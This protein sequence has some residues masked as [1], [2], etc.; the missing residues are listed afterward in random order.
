MKFAKN[1]NSNRPVLSE[2]SDINKSPPHKKHE[3]LESHKSSLEKILRFIK[4]SISK[5][6]SNKNNKNNKSLE[7][8]KEM[9]IE[10][11]QIFRYKL[12]EKKINMDFFENLISEKKSAITNKIFLDKN[13]SG[14]YKNSKN[15]KIYNLKTEIDLLK[16][17]NF[18]A[19]NDIQFINNSM[20]KKTNEYNYLK[21]Y[22]PNSTL[23]EKETI[24]TQQ[25]YYPIVTKIIHKKLEEVHE[26]F[27]RITSA[28]KKQNKLIE[29]INNNLV[30]LKN[31]IQRRK[32]NFY[33]NIKE[34]IKE[35][36]KEYT[37]TMLNITVNNINNVNNIISAYNKINKYN[38][39]KKEKDEDIKENDFD[40]KEENDDDDI[41]NQDDSNSSSNSSKENNYNNKIQQTKKIPGLN[42]D[43]DKCHYNDDIKYNT[44]RDQ[45]VNSYFIN[46]KSQRFKNAIPHILTSRKEV[47]KAD[48]INNI[49][50]DKKFN[51]IN[52]SGDNI[53]N[54]SDIST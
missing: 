10:L 54:S 41:F 39:K 1:I 18:K 30:D 23:Q 6:V 2:T 33:P 15:Q 14:K 32:Y 42:L 36:S 48:F 24:C 53:S 47:N 45:N 5:I 26:K 12:E 51:N 49:F 28:K 37:K 31:S 4:E 38:L 11:N 35:E 21:L 27:K 19:T 25:K 50:L 34:I 9:L 46:Q 44:S 3:I 7:E 40:E 17:L 29:N 43:L 13:K 22:V 20:I 52:I 16:T 8:V